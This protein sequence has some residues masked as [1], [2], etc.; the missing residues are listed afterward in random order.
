[1]KNIFFIISIIAFLCLPSASIQAQDQLMIAGTVMDEMGEP[2]I[3]ANVTVQGNSAIGTITDL[4]GKFRLG[5]LSKG[6]IVQFS[7]IGYQSHT[8]K[9][10]QS[11][12]RLKIVLD[13]D[14]NALEEVVVVG[15]SEQRKVSVTGAITAIKPAIINTPA[16]SI[17]NML[18]GNV[19]GIIA[20]TRSGEPGNDFSEFWIR[21]IST[22]GANSSALVLVD[23]VEGNLNDLDP[24]DIES[25][26]VLKD[27]S[28]TAVYGVRGANGVVVVT[29]KSGK[30]GKLRVNFKTNL[31]MSESGR[32]PEYADAYSYAQLANEA[33][34]GRGEAPRYTDTQLELFRT[35]L[36][37][38]LYPNVNWR[39][40]ILRDHVWQNQHYLSVSGG[41]T[42]AR[43]YLSLSMQNKDAVFK[44][45]KSVNKYNTNVS[46]HKYSFMGKIDANLTK[47]TVLGLKFNQLLIDQNSPGYGDNNNALWS[48]QAN[49]TP[50]TLPVRYSTG[51]LSSYGSNADQM[52]PYV[53]L[54]YT[55]FKEFRRADTDLQ[56]TLNQNLDFITKGLK[57]SG[58]F[59]YYGASE[60]SIIR[61]KRPD[62]YIADG[63]NADGTLS[64]RRTL[65]KQDLSFNKSTYTSRKYYWELK[66]NYDRKFGD[67]RV[68]AL[69]LFYMQSSTNSNANSNLAAIPKRYESLSGRA[70]YSFKDTYFAEVNLGYTGSEQFPKGDRFGLFPAFSAGWI[71]TQYKFIQKAFPF[72]DY[73]KF[74]ASYGIVGN[75]RLAGDVRF[76]YL[77]TTS[78]GTGGWSGN[79]ITESQIGTDGLTWE[80]AKKFDVGVDVHLFN[81]KLELTVDY[82]LDR[83]SDI[84]Q[85]RASI[86]EE[87]GLISLPWANVGSMKSWGADGNITF[88]H[89]FNKDWSMTLR[90]N[91]TFARNKV[92]HWEESDV[93][94]PYQSRIGYTNGIN[95]GLIA[96][97][98]FKDEADIASSPRQTFESKV[99]P[100]D[101]KYKDV[102]GDG[103]IDKEDEVPL[104]Y[105][106]TPEL[107]YGF[108]AEFRW[109]KFSISAL[110]EGAGRSSFFFGGTGYYPFAWEETGN[111]L[112]IVTNPDNRWIPCEISGN[113]A[114]ENPNARFPRLTYGENKNNNRNSTFYL[115]NNDYLRFKNLTFRYGFQNNW[116]RDHIGIEG[117][118][119]SFIVQNICTW[120]NVKLWDPGQATSNGTNYP[121]QRTY[122]LQLNFNF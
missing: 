3:G 33:L 37:P 4:D 118:D 80:T 84:F 77:T 122:T 25:F 36:D 91:F 96:L 109:K 31:I 6:T 49:L 88:N 101:I 85:Q 104:N 92:L 62:L 8:Y 112:N 27:A 24:S 97:G 63:R 32:M 9:V 86:P 121:I 90:G 47:T 34:L 93:R 64:L 38:D 98:L 55:G 113:P 79:Y 78:T 74:R 43:Y 102:N 22:F 30:A 17:T 50:V 29:T 66:G 19:P 87:S 117:I 56:V 5:G 120:D 76:P 54:N 107:Q 108:A 114:T 14:A 111:L 65:S 45:D 15:Q 10:G 75:D 116:L 60:H 106:T 95:R 61:S 105:S 18:G 41:G 53:Q 39:D 35:G 12:E 68:G 70:T 11:K 69:A 72:L 110:F 28:A 26:S 83:R 20:V 100:G 71:P 89:T 52:S 59:S 119:L 46:Y 99:L 40:V 42:A 103:V 94:Y 21:G 57:V 44:Q 115:V 82:F 23:G 48:A 2:L 16:T 58:L 73:L 7:Y 1:M 67:H 81:N 13:P 51:E